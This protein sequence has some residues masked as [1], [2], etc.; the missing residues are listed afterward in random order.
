MKRD[1]TVH[2]HH[3]KV[4]DLG[5]HSSFEGDCIRE[6]V[7]KFEEITGLVLAESS[8]RPSE[9]HTHGSD[10]LVG[11]RVDL[12]R[13]GFLFLVFGSRKTLLGDLDEMAEIPVEFGIFS[14]F[15]VSIVVGNIGKQDFDLSVIAHAVQA[16]RTS[17]HDV[18]G[19]VARVTKHP[20]THLFARAAPLLFVRGLWDISHLS[21]TAEF[22][23]AQW[24]GDRKNQSFVFN[25]IRLSSVLSIRDAVVNAVELRPLP[26]GN[27]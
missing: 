13:I 20:L 10:A 23:L 11:F 14:R 21:E 8:R 18:S 15:D 12:N 7:A 5:E 27:R 2:S 17:E 1:G 6:L 24:R 4:D 3:K 19:K 16:L 22:G 25:R 9:R 26:R